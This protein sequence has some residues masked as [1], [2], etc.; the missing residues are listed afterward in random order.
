M[1]RQFGTNSVKGQEVRS[2]Q[3]KEAA[4]AAEFQRKIERIASA[5]ILGISLLVVILM[6]ISTNHYNQMREAT[7]LK[8]NEAQDTLNSIQNDVYDDT[9]NVVE[10]DAVSKTAAGAGEAVCSLQNDLNKVVN[11]EDIE[12]AGTFSDEHMMLLDR[13]QKYF[14]SDKANKSA[15]RGTWCK[16]G[17]WFFNGIYEYEGNDVTVVWKCYAPEDKD[18]ERLLAFVVATYDSSSDTFSNG[19]VMYTTWYEDLANAE[20]DLVEEDQGYGGDDPADYM[21]M[22]E[23]SGEVAPSDSVSGSEA[24]PSVASEGNVPGVPLDET[25]DPVYNDASRR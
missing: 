13:V 20:N 12:A 23:D 22:E 9:H 10:V 16:Y 6:M 3:M 11:A 17:T 8:L 21:D 24:A 18:Q 5:V 2:R 7:L 25:E 1:S 14:P 19:E 4:V 15:V